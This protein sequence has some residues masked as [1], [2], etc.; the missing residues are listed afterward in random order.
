LAKARAGTAVPNYDIC[1]HYT[2]TDVQSMLV[3]SEKFGFE[4][5]RKFTDSDSSKLDHTVV[6]MANHGFTAVGAS[7]KQAV[8]RAVYTHKNAGVQSSALLLRAASLSAGD[9]LDGHGLRYLNKEQVQGSLKMNLATED[10]PWGLWV[11]E[12]KASPL[13]ENE[14]DFARSSDIDIISFEYPYTMEGF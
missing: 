10:R 8:Y 1:D 4:L 2:P 5:A 11:K 7:I 13:Y 12:V 9:S 6:L 3:N 14:L